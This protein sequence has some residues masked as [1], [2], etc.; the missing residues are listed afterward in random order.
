LPSAS[1]DPCTML[2]GGSTRMDS[3]QNP[4]ADTSVVK[5][6]A[7]PRSTLKRRLFRAALRAFR[8]NP[9][10]KTDLTRAMRQVKKPE[11]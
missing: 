9:P 7:A 5:E 1:M 10:A 2:F 3:V 8:M 11:V 4:P 6:T